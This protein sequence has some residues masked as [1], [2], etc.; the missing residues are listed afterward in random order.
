[1]GVCPLEALVTGRSLIQGVLPIVSL[2]VITLNNSP[3]HT[4][5]SGR[6]KKRKLVTVFG[7]WLISHLTYLFGCLMPCFVSFFYW[8]DSLF[9]CLVYLVSWFVV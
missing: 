5:C 3:L 4:Q 7:S 8:L 1:M 2:C 6:K 9:S